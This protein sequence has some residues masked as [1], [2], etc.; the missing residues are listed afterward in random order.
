MDTSPALKLGGD[1]PEGDA[2]IVLPDPTNTMASS[3]ILA[4][5]C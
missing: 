5:S 4:Q 1:F 2:F 3:V